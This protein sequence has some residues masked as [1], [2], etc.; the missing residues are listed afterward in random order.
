MKL[1]LN[2]FRL[3]IDARQLVCQVQSGVDPGSVKELR[4]RYRDGWCLHFREGVVYGLPTVTGAAPFGE[5][6]MLDATSHTALSVLAARVNGLVPSLFP[7][8]ATIRQRPFTFEG[9]RTECVDAA[10]KASGVTHPLLRHFTI[11]PKLAIDCRL[12][13]PVHGDLGPVLTFATATK[14]TVDAPLVELARA[15]VPL[16]GLYAIRRSPG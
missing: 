10:G 6:R 4:E 11:R 12:L 3:R 1:I 13:E 9:L 7:Q 5:E 8:Y 2:A 15:G 14:W 16:T